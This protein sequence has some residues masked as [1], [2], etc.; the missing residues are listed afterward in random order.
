MI[1][2]LAA[3]LNKR[4]E[5]LDSFTDY[6]PALAYVFVPFIL[7]MKQPDLGTSAGFYG[8]FAWDAA[9]QRV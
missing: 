9:H 8:N 1:V 3:F 5:T 7:V 6:L 2:C 4:L